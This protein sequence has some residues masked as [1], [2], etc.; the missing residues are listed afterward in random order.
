M[1]NINNKEEGKLEIYL[2]NIQTLEKIDLQF[3]NILDLKAN[4]EKILEFNKPLKVKE[5]SSNA[6]FKV[7]LTLISSDLNYKKNKALKFENFLIEKK[8]AL[9]TINNCL[10]H[11]DNTLGK[12]FI[13][14]NKG[15]DI[16]F[17]FAK[18]NNNKDKYYLS[19]DIHYT[20]K[21]EN[22]C[23]KIIGKDIFKWDWMIY[24]FNK[25]MFLLTL[26]SWFYKFDFSTVKFFLK[27]YYIFCYSL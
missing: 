9:E 4:E 2:H 15:N 18:N 6:K 8:E 23:L 21:V 17:D 7:S 1:I 10:S 5:I 20:E 14:R 25:I 3:F 22:Y 13:E 27:S 16:A 19:D 26:F 12:Y 11:I 24:F